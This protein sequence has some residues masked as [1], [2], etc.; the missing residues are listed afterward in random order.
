MLPPRRPFKSASVELSVFPKKSK[1][2]VPELLTASHDE[3][4]E[5][6][7]AAVV[8]LGGFPADDRV[9][10]ALLEALRDKSPPSAPGRLRLAE[11]AA[12]SL[13]ELEGGA[14]PAIPA[15]IEVARHGTT[16][17]R[18][19]A[20]RALGKIGEKDRKLAPKVLP[21]LVEV[22]KEKDAGELR[23]MA[24]ALLGYL[25]E[26]AKRAIPAFREVMALK[27]VADA[28][29][30][31]SI[32]RN[33]LWSLERMGPIAADAVPEVAAVLEDPTL[34]PEDYQAA[35]YALKSMG[36]KVPAAA[37]ALTRASNSPIKSVRNA[38]RKALDGK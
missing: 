36:P 34:T 1:E 17:L 24:A 12:S 18:D 31:S 35:A 15:L 9:V 3:K 5:V 33:I 14:A 20:L 27:D 29:V 19:S 23:A 7:E 21:V 25:K 37:A 6:R 30:A 8:A 26:D 28:E 2:I 11:I 10:P 13:G 4:I 32:R 38:A 22:L 16:E